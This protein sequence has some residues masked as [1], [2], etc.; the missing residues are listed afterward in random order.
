MYLSFPQR[1]EGGISWESWKILRWAW[2][3]SALHSASDTRFEE[4][5][6]SPANSIYKTPYS[7]IP[8]HSNDNKQSKASG[9]KEPKGRCFQ[10]LACFHIPSVSGLAKDS[11]TTP[12]ASLSNI[13]TKAR[14][15]NALS[16]PQPSES[17]TFGEDFT[18]TLPLLLVCYLKA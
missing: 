13:T 6:P 2:F 18:N 4:Q 3:S 17:L 5:S 11:W 15:G 8:K 1:Q 16:L 9:W 12:P 7:V 10:D 14:Q